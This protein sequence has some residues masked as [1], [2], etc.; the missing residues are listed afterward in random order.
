M[1]NQDNAAEVEL[2][3]ASNNTITTPE[4]KLEH[5]LEDLTLFERI[6]YAS[7]PRPHNLSK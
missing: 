1:P 5:P 4:V 2:G 6:R 7:I 3:T